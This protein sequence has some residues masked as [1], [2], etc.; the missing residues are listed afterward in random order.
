MK[1]KKALAASIALCVVMASSA[2]NAF[3]IETQNENATTSSEIVSENQIEIKIKTLTNNSVTISNEDGYTDTQTVNENGFAIFTTSAPGRYYVTPERAKTGYS[4]SEEPIGYFEITEDGQIIAEGSLNVMDGIIYIKELG[5]AVAAVQVSASPNT[6][7]QFI[8]DE[9]TREIVTDENGIG[10]FQFSS[11]D[12]G[13]Y[14]VYAIYDDSEETEYVYLGDVTLGDGLNFSTSED[15]C[16]TFEDSIIYINDN[17]EIEESYDIEAIFPESNYGLTY[18]II[19]ADNIPTDQSYLSSGTVESK[20]TIDK[21]IL[22]VNKQGNYII[23]YMDDEDEDDVK[24][25]KF[26]LFSVNEEGKF[27]SDDPAF[28]IKD[29]V[30]YID[31]LYTT[32]T[33]SDSEKDSSNAD[34][35]SDSVDATTNLESNTDSNTSNT[36]RTNGG[37]GTTTASGNNTPNPNTGVAGVGLSLAAL[38]AAGIVVSKKK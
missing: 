32:D 30:A 7:Y 11:E 18:I 25:G 26:I 4:E 19:D 23:T 36:T 21:N 5:P 37:T 31:L 34:E 6:T 2:I 12:K 14:N 35:S 29:D 20:D 1:I 16:I 3:A 24:Y 38:V 8:K 13:T 33:S 9:E 17:I 28:V 27:V 22:S 15:S 10:I